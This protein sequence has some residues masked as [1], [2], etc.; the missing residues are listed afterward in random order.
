ML[1]RMISLKDLDP[2]SRSHGVS[3]IQRSE[4][5]FKGLLI[6][7][8]RVHAFE[9]FLEIGCYIKIS[10]K[11]VILHSSDY[12]LSCLLEMDYLRET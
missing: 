12:I 9:E 7:L 6:W 10:H 5:F 8:F 4:L 11:N 3:A 1:G 2:H